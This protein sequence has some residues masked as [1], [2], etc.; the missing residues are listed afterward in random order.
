MLFSRISLSE[1]C[2]V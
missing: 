2:C 1:T